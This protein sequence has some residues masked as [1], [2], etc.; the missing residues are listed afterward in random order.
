LFVICKNNNEEDKENIITMKDTNPE[1][2]NNKNI[3][4]QLLPP[5]NK[6]FYMTL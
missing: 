6:L 4:R 5:D 2:K 1:E 3:T